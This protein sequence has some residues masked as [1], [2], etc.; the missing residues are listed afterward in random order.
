MQEEER[1]KHAS[2]K[3]ET[4]SDEKEITVDE[5]EVD[6]EENWVDWIRHGTKQVE[7]VCI[8][9]NIDDWEVAQR[10]GKWRWTGHVARR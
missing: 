3:N 8:R 6:A 1:I 7:D 4:G 9:L 5:Y 10:K 2:G